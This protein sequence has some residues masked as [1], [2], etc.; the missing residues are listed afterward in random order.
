[1]INSP[2]EANIWQM[3]I[4]HQ[5]DYL[6]SIALAG[7]NIGIPMPEKYVEWISWK[8]GEKIAGDYMIPYNSKLFAD[9]LNTLGTYW[10]YKLPSVSI[11][12][13]IP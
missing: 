3:D 8:L 10:M 13:C 4:D 12:H 5:L 6:E 1:M 11:E 2:I 9:D 7:C